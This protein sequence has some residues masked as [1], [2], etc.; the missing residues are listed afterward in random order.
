MD[1]LAFWAYSGPELE[2]DFYYRDT[3]LLN[4]YVLAG[5]HGR[6]LCQFIR[7]ESV[8]PGSGLI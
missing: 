4:Y 7:T 6:W 3:F 2:V 5:K 8:G 1:Q